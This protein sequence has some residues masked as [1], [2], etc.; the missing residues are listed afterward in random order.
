MES[1]TGH[2]FIDNAKVRSNLEEGVGKSL[3]MSV[4]KI[5]IQWA[6][7]CRH[8]EKYTAEALTLASKFRLE[9]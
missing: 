8:A 1:G 5:C 6:E 3:G 9:N 7:Q 2:A 4:D